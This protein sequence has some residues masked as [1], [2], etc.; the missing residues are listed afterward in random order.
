MVDYFSSFRQQTGVSIESD[1]EPK[2]RSLRPSSSE[3]GGGDH[4]APIEVTEIKQVDSGS[5]APVE[6]HADQPRKETAPPPRVPPPEPLQ[7]PASNETAT[8]GRTLHGI[9]QPSRGRLENIQMTARP[10]P[11]LPRCD[12]QKN[13]PKDLSRANGPSERIPPME[14]T[15]ERKAAVA[16]ADRPL[17]RS[18]TF[19]TPFP[20]KQASVC[21]QAPQDQARP[22][23]QIRQRVL[24]QVRRWVASQ[25]VLATEQQRSQ[26]TTKVAD[27][28]EQALQKAPGEKQTAVPGTTGKQ[29]TGEPD[30][31]VHDLH[32]SIGPLNITVEQPELD[33]RRTKPQPRREARAASES[34]TSRLRRH[35]IRI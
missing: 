16:K 22:H 6:D 25:P 34:G 29:I 3:F 30:T 32:L 10:E 5:G 15:V 12:S 8:T 23:E 2:G 20:D 11:E 33:K 7:R 17:R 13:P 27:E 9:F 19:E 18:P 14:V 24:K 26:V 35:H 21:T 1:I 31:A 4:I 28:L